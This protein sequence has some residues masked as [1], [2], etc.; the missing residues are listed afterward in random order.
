MK[1]IYQ[2]IKKWSKGVLITNCE[3]VIKE[4]DAKLKQVCFKI[5]TY[6][7]KNLTDWKLDQVISWTQIE[8][9]FDS[10]LFRV[11]FLLGNQDLLGFDFGM[12]NSEKFLKL[13][14]GQ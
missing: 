2:K 3:K 12:F 10:L 6:L 4:N 14:L 7:F 1:K 13:S 8:T 5:H 11:H 9:P